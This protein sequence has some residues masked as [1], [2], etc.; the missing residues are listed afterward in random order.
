MKDLQI[1]F[2]DYFCV[3]ESIIEKYGAVNISLINDLPLFIDPFLLFNSKKIVYQRIHENIIKYLLFLQENAEKNPKPSPGMLESWYLFS[4]VKQTWLGF[5]LSGN[6]GRGL[7]KK[8]A[9]ELYTGLNTIFKDFG[10]ETITKSSHLEKLCLISPLVGR[11]KISDFVTNFTK[12]YI[13]KYTENFARKHL[14]ENKCKTF[15]VPRVEFNYITKSWKSENYYLPCYKGDYVLLTPRDMLTR[16]ETFINRPDMIKNLE[17]IAPAIEDSSLRFLLNQYL[18]EVLPLKKKE[19][20]KT[21]KESKAISLVTTHPELIDYYIQYKENTEEQATSISKQVVSEVRQLFNCQLQKLANILNSKTQ[22]YSVIPNSRDAAYQR[23]MYLKDVIENKDGYRI[24]YINGQPIKRELDLQIMYRL[25]WYATD[26]DVNREVNNGRGPVDY[27]VSKGAEDSTL[28][29]FKLASNSKLK[30]NL[31]NQVEIY[32][33]ANSTNN[34]IKV[35]LYF[36]ENEYTKIMKILQ[37][38]NLQEGSDL[39]LIDARANK[40]SASNAG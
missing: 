7:G 5:S 34:A 3:N 10:K 9:E 2:S 35:I 18:N 4:E 22:F 21:E 27:K 6:S 29:E 24:F 26:F 33:K 1:F 32:K 16:D 30:K 12:K 11:D 36:T 40:I 31:E 39:V 20:S 8:F 25:V 28:V 15:C 23:V 14:E 17:S 19:M 38:L 13:L 37:D